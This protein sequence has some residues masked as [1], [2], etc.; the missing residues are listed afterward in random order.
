MAGGGSSGGAVQPVDEAVARGRQG[1]AGG[2]RRLVREGVRREEEAGQAQ[3]GEDIGGRDGGI[4]GRREEAWQR[5]QAVAVGSGRRGRD[6]TAA[7]RRDKG[8][9]VGAAG[10]GAAGEIEAEAEV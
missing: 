7:L 6:G 5:Q 3:A 4:G 9:I 1:T 8:E 2:G 10:D